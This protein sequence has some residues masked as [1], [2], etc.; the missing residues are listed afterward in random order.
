MKSENENENIR[1]S[2]RHAP[3][4]ARCLNVVYADAIEDV[5]N[6]AKNMMKVVVV[7]DVI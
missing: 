6:H 7:Q 3:A 4:P 2:N 5:S 1:F